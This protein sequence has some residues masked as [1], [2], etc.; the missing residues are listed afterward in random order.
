M[1]FIIEGIKFG[2]PFSNEIANALTISED[3]VFKRIYKSCPHTWTEIEMKTTIDVIA[4][5]A[6]CWNVA[7][8]SYHNGVKLGLSVGIMLIILAF[9]VPN[10]FMEPFVNKICGNDEE[11]PENNC[12]HLIRF[13]AA[14]GF[15]IILLICEYFANKFLISLKLSKR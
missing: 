15:V 11:S 8:T 7:E 13:F 14:V 2:A 5:T 1:E 10:L 6:I 4:L 3:P 12:G 9:I